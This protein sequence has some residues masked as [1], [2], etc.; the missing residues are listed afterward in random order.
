MET[1]QITINKTIYHIRDIEWEDLPNLNLYGLMVMITKESQIKAP[2]VQQVMKENGFSLPLT[3]DQESIMN[4]Q[5]LH[6]PFSEADTQTLLK[7]QF[8]NIGILNPFIKAMVVSP[9]LKHL[10]PVV[11]IQLSK[12]PVLI[13][14]IQ[15]LIKDFMALQPETGPQPAKK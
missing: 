9:S 10:K 12:H 5:M 8:D 15:T 14:K 6:L 7:N 3:K 1:E 11:G 4:E 13:Q 2:Y